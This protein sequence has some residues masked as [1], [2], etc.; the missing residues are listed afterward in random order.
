MMNPDYRT[1]AYAILN[2]SDKK[3][4]RYGSISPMVVD[5]TKLG[6]GIEKAQ[7]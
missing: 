7:F 1:R 6:I 2:W 5:P 4:L 3:L